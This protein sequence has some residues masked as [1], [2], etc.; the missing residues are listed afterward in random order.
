MLKGSPFGKYMGF[1]I[2][3]AASSSTAQAST[4]AVAKKGLDNTKLEGKQA[5]KLI[6]SATAPPP[7]RGG[8]LSVYA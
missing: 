4:V 8:R 7:T 6:D 3:A 1:S 2:S 5:L